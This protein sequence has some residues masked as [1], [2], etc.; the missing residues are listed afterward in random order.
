LTYT[1][2]ERIAPT[3]VCVQA[4]RVLRYLGSRLSSGNL[5]PDQ[6]DELRTSLTAHALLPCTRLRAGPGRDRDSGDLSWEKLSVSP[7][8]PT[9]TSSLVCI[10]DD[11]HLMA[12]LEAGLCSR[13]GVSSNDVVLS[14]DLAVVRTQP[15]GWPACLTLA[16]EVARKQQVPQSQN[17]QPASDPIKKE[18]G[19]LSGSDDE[20]SDDGSSSDQEMETVTR[21]GRGGREV[22]RPLRGHTDDP[23]LQVARLLLCL[24]AMPLSHAV[25]RVVSVEGDRQLG[26]P[27]EA[28]ALAALPAAQAFIWARAAERDRSRYRQYASLVEPLIPSFEV[29]VIQGT[30]RCSIS[31]IS[32]QGNSG[33]RSAGKPLGS[34][35]SAVL[36]EG[37]LYVA[38]HHASDFHAMSCELSRSVAF[39]CPHLDHFHQNGRSWLPG[40]ALTSYSCYQALEVREV[41]SCASCTCAQVVLRRPSF[42]T[43]PV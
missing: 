29:H 16:V 4:L 28:H 33:D 42:S 3:F 34:Q 8:S 40:C 41:L 26:A 2:L 39:N 15:V 19:D 43:R 5:H 14:S 13:R 21:V 25:T 17:H 20:M 11:P 36:H 32:S 12:A 24:G 7:T 37:R 23:S 10:N 9:S 35:V 38:A 30:V 22:G 18:N 6:L 27:L 31:S 1:S